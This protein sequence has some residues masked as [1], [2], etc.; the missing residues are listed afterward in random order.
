LQTAPIEVWAIVPTPHFRARRRRPPQTVASSGASPPTPEQQ[1]IARVKE[2]FPHLWELLALGRGKVVAAGAAM[3]L[4]AL[5]GH[6]LVF[7]QQ[8][9]H[10]ELFFHHM[11]DE[12]EA[13][14]LLTRMITILSAAGNS[15]ETPRCK[16][17]LTRTSSM[18]Q[19]SLCSST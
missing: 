19:V 10:C 9:G 2:R 6:E 8:H 17:L 4:S 1:A 7:Q 12:E 16:V 11:K 5:D 18:V 14:E 15:V 13:N 3:M